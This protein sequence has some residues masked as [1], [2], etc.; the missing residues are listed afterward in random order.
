[1]ARKVLLDIRLKRA[2]TAVLVGATLGASGAAMQSVL[3]NPL[4]SPFALGIQHAAAPGAALALMAL[5]GARV[6]RFSIEVK[7]PFLVTGLAFCGGLASDP[8]GPRDL[9]SGGA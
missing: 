9:L 7:S 1:V 6:Q 4:A 8:F 5:Y 2:V 3:R